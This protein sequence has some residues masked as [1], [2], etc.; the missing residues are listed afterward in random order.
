M[1]TT[2]DGIPT[3]LPQDFTTATHVTRFY[4]P[5]TA[6]GPREPP[7]W[8]FWLLLLAVLACLVLYVAK[9]RF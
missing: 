5:P 6:R 4:T 9:V 2:S 7:A 1:A 8:L 3:E